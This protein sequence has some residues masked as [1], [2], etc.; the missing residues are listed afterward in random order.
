M[1][2]CLLVAILIFTVNL[3]S[4]NVDLRL[5]RDLRTPGIRVIGIGLPRT[6]TCSLAVA[7]KRVGLHVQH[8]PINL[9]KKLELY[10]SKRNALVDLSMLNLRPIQVHRM[11]PDAR[12]IYTYRSETSW[13]RSMQ[14]LLAFLRNMTLVPGIGQTVNNIDRIFGETSQSLV[15]AKRLYEEEVDCLEAAG[16]PVYRIP[17]VSKETSDRTK[18]KLLQRAVQ[19]ET[20]YSHLPFPYESHVKLHLKQAWSFL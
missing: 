4:F 5:S 12:L 15:R 19:S 7:L 14:E 6:G 16:I 17:I 9:V 13:V 8:F 20:D 10:T 11:F 3:F 18:W 2:V 1:T